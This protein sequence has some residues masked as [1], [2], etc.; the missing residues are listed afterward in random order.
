MYKVCG[1]S[2]A[3]FRW[4]SGYGVHFERGR[5]GVR[6]PLASG[7]FRGRVIPMTSKLALHWLPCQAPWRYRVSAGTGRP[8]VSIL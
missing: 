7:Y 2:P 1:S 6:F 3:P 5:S 8:G 4:P